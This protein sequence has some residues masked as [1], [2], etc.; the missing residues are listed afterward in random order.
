MSFSSE[1]KEDLSKINNLNNKEIIK[2]ELMGYLI[3]SNTRFVNKSKIKFTTESEYNINRFSRLL[4]NFNMNHNIELQGKNYIIKFNTCNVQNIV[5]IDIENKKI[6]LLEIPN[7]EENI[8]SFV[9][10]VFLGS[11]LVSS[12]KGKYHLELAFTDEQNMNDMLQILKV[13]GIEAKILLKKRAFSL[14]LKESESIS[15]FLA[16][17]G[18]N[19][20]VIKFEEMRVMKQI[21]NNV[22]RLVNCE[23]AN[24]HK[25]VQAA[26][27][28]QEAIRKIEKYGKFEELSDQLKEISLLRKEHPDASL[29]E[30]GSM[31][32]NPIGK[33]GV[34]HRLK[35]IVQIAD[36]L[37]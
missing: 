34:N 28:E 11:G 2:Y 26:V 30:L 7:K 22:N 29:V 5:N 24:L 1:I 9:K 4:S 14:Y 18:A 16:L 10:G 31:L 20:A 37:K 6:T 12:S 21:S 33:S 15:T 25:T 36:E 35:K 32:E 27:V 19:K 17:I 13:Y 3:S 8:K 23:T